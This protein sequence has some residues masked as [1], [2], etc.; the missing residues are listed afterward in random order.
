MY[1]CVY[2]CL[3]VCLKGWAKSRLQYW[4]DHGNLFYFYLFIFNF[5]SSHKHLWILMLTRICATVCQCQ[6][7]IPGMLQCWRRTFWAP[8]KL[9]ND[10]IS[11]IDLLLAHSVYTHTYTKRGGGGGNWWIEQTDREAQI[12][13]QKEH[14]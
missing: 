13:R 6:G 5:H 10:P 3:K 1:V 9:N 11:T 7:Q 12:N 2:T 4:L 14:L 8:K